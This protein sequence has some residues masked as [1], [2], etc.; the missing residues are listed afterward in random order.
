M[1][2]SFKF[3]YNNSPRTAIIRAVFSYA[4]TAC[5]ENEKAIKSWHKTVVFHNVTRLNI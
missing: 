1:K 4:K 5:R 2:C 3:S